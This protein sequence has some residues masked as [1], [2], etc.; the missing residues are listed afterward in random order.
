M[1]IVAKYINYGIKFPFVRGENGYYLD[2]TKSETEAI[3]SSLRH[4]LLTK[5]GERLMRPDFGTN[6]L[7]YIFEQE[8]PDTANKIQYEIQDIVK[9]YL[10]SITIEKI[11]IDLSEQKCDMFINYTINSGGFFTKDTLNITI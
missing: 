6:I 7:T 4:L 3:K 5:K 10:P 11:Q 2:T 9:K 1:I 8:H